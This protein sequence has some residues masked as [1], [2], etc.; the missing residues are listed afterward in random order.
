MMD[1]FMPWGFWDFG[2]IMFGLFFIIFICIFGFI[3]FKLISQ[4]IKNNNSPRLTVPAIVS[5]KRT[6]VSGGGTSN[7]VSSSSTW[8]YA[9]FEVESGDRMELLVGGLEY[10]LLAEGDKGKLTFQG[11]RYIQFERVI[12]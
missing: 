3:I 4:A 10:G 1:I 6:R 2:G 8:Y 7:T 9:T 5:G 11:T 12:T